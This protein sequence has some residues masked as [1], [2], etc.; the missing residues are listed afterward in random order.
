[1]RIDRFV[2]SL[3][4][5][6]FTAACGSESVEAT[7]EFT[8]ACANPGDPV[9]ITVSGFRANDCNDLRVADFAGADAIEPPFERKRS[10]CVPTVPMPAAEPGPVSVARTLGG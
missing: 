2:S 5:V 9:T 1:M 10:T 4:A 6:V 7:V 3:V 8:P